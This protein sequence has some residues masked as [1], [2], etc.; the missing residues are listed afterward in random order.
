VATARPVNVRLRN[1]PAS[2]MARWPRARMMRM[3]PARHAAASAYS[4][5]LAA[6]NQPLMFPRM[7]A[8][9]SAARNTVKAAMPAQSG[10]AASCDRDS[11]SRDAAARRVTAPA[12]AFSKKIHRHPGPLASAPPMSGPAADP[13][14]MAAPNALN[15]A[16][17]SLP[18]NSCPSSAGPTANMT[19]AP[20]PCTPR[21]TFSRSMFPASPQASDAT[22]K[23]ARPETKIRLRPMRSATDPAVTRNAARVRA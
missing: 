12:G 1:M 22:V 8:S 2:N 11:R 18:W 10:A 21:P 23:T 6:E 19:A 7:I 4:P 15:A 20:A 14:P 3:K 17:R 5:V 16:A 13:I 9:T